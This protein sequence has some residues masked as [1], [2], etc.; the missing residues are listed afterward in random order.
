MRATEQIVRAHSPP[1]LAMHRMA[2]YRLSAQLAI[3]QEITI[4]YLA[5]TAYTVLQNNGGES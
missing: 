1:K 3:G 5:S 4:D 2:A